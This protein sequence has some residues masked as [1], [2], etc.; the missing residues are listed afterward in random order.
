MNA[1]IL[2]TWKLVSASTSTST[3]ERNATPFGTTPT[4][5]LTYTQDGRMS[6]M[7]SYSGRKRLSS[8]DSF[9][10]PTEEQ[11]EAF[12]TFIAYAGRFTLNDD[13]II[14][15]VEISSIQ[16]WVDTD[17]IRSIKFV[18]DRIIFATPSTPSGGKMHIFE[19]VWQR[20]SAISR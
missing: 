20:L 1:A 17:L 13:K 19:L 16:D 10:A 7:I 3:G 4:G 18:D 2:G 9:S 15:H 5:F 12:R 6:A 14:H 11:A 8:P